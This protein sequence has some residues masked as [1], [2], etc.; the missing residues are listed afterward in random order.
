MCSFHVF[1]FLVPDIN[2][3]HRLHLQTKD[4]DIHIDYS[5][6]IT[7]SQGT[8]SSFYREC[9]KI[10]EELQDRGRWSEARV[11]AELVG[12]S[13]INTTIN[14]VERLSFASFLDNVLS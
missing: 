11:A 1:L 6:L 10:V 4:T 2:L 9:R 5:H 7:S 12:M 8:D 14:Q 13:D 3:L